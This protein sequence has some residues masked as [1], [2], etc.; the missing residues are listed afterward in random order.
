M[1]ESKFFKSTA[2]QHHEHHETE[3]AKVTD[4]RE[5]AHESGLHEGKKRNNRHQKN[6]PKTRGEAKMKITTASLLTAIAL[7]V[8]FV[9]GLAADNPARAAEVK[10]AEEQITNVNA[11]DFEVFDVQRSTFQ[12]SRL[13]AFDFDDFDFKVFD[14]KAENSENVDFKAGDFNA[15]N[16]RRFEFRPV[17]FNGFNFQ[18]FE[19]REAFKA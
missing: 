18:A 12:S 3:V 4:K 13:V 17:D 10:V 2:T 5:H 14:F 15:L 7:T 8:T 11:I 9:F 1:K 19:F 6:F 16:F